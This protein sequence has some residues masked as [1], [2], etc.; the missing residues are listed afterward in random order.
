[1]KIRLSRVTKECNV[2]L[3]TIV[4]FLGK[5]GIT[6]DATP[7]AAINE[8]QYE[9]LKKE[10]GADQALRDKADKERQIRQLG[11][12]NTTKEKRNAPQEI[13]TQVPE[14]MRPKVVMKGHIDLNAKPQPAPQSTPVKTEKQTTRQKKRKL[15]QKILPAIQKSL[16]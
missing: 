15:R 6:V 8:E 7:N 10:Y 2:G 12:K 16:T 11:R 5:K 3:Q 13:K 4:E 1:M 9:M 14:D